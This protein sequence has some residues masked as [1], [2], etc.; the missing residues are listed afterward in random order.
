MSLALP[1]KDYY[2]KT[3]TEA[4]YL[5]AYHRYMTE[6]AVLLGANRTTAGPELMEVIKFEKRLANVRIL[7][8]KIHTFFSE[9]FASD[10]ESVACST[11]KI[12]E[13]DGAFKDLKKKFNSLSSVPE[14]ASLPEADRHDTSQIYKKMSVKQLH[15]LVPQID[16]L[17]YLQTFLHKPI[18][19][20]EHVV[21]YGLTYFAYMGKVLKSTPP[22]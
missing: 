8:V 12:I 18:D 1:S 13:H 3:N 7:C 20:N 5:G 10:T 6:V 14:Q 2:L 15:N 19:E 9:R 22:R 16:W 4:D 21:A 17:Q 11:V